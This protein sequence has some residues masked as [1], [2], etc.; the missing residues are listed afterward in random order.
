MSPS[1]TNCTED[2]NELNAYDRGSSFDYELFSEK[3]NRKVQNIQHTRTSKMRKVKRY[4]YF[5]F[6]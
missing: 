3:P 2:L 6:P 5:N 1:R 4:I